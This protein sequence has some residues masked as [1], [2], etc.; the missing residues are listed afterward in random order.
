MSARVAIMF[1]PLGDPAERVE[2]YKRFERLFGAHNVLGDVVNRVL[3]QR[4]ELPLHE[5]EEDISR[6]IGAALG[7][8]LK[9]NQA[10]VR[11]CLLGYGED[12]VVLLRTNVNLLID[13]V[14]LLAE[15]RTE[16]FKNFL[17]HSY[18]ERAKMFR[19][20]YAEPPPWPPPFGDETKKR[21]KAW[22]TI[23][24]RAA[25]LPENLRLLHYSQGYRLYSALEHSDAWGLSDYV[26]PPQESGWVAGSE[27]GDRHLDLVLAHAWRVLADL[28]SLF[29]Q[30]FAIER[31]A[32]FAELNRVWQDIGDEG[33]SEA[34]SSP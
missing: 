15:D 24:A 31:S 33:G 28:F 17:A 13:A 20:G 22:G 29:C 2:R 16:R 34:A 30:Y 18:D 11:L 6:F 26:T 23:N 4:G 3:D 12:A 5:G 19:E 7:K 9:T 21:A 25:A 1:D 8:A 27:E 32:A 14:Y 10:I